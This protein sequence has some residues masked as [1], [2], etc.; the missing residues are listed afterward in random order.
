MGEIG[1]ERGGSQS[2][3]LLEDHARTQTGSVLTH[4][5]KDENRYLLHDDQSGHSLHNRDST[6][7][8][9]GVVSALGS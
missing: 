3:I 2:G 6:R 1:K 7:N 4:D 9:T 5:R 8:D